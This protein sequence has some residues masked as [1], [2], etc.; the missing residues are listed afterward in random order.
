MR[1]GRCVRRAALLTRTGL[2]VVACFVA[3]QFSA[4]FAQSVASAGPVNAREQRGSLPIS[5]KSDGMSVDSKDKT[6]VFSGKVVAR[7]GDI[8]IYS[9][10]LIV[11][12]AANRSD[13]EKIEAVG[14]VH[15]VQD[16][17]VAS[18]QRAIYD[19]VK[20][21]I[22]LTGS[23]KVTQGADTITGKVITYHVD[24]EKSEVVGDSKTRVN[25]IINPPARKNNAGQ[26]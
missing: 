23:P 6:A 20:G 24:E 12:Y 5:I 26:R 4:G 13:V 14:S 18:A 17:R 3:M 22:T 1:T 19:N 11:N 9:D 21:L 2:V 10:K 8:T 15:I 25:V 7:Q 16:N